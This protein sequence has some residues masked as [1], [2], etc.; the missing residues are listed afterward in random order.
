[1]PG[2]RER[3]LQGF[4]SLDFQS[5]REE[6][7][8]RRRANLP[9]L[10]ELAHQFKERL[11]AAGGRFHHARSAAEARRIIAEICQRAGAGIV[12][13]SKSM[14]TEE[15]ELNHHLEGLG[16]EVVETDLGEYI[17]Q[18]L[19]IRPAHLIAPAVHLTVED[20]A[21]ELGTPADKEQILAHARQELRQKFIQAAV[22]ISGANA[23][24]A[25]T[26]TVMIVT[27]EG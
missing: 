6:L 23:A 3:R 13:K 16:M 25:E 11:E 2:L 4:Q 17:V 27:N 15:I 5:G 20:W 14:A 18:R 21:E 24:I 22:G 10:P 26:G 19:G 9:H 7:K 1:M 12:T 8:R